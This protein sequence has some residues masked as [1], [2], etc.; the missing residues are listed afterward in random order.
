MNHITCSRYTLLFKFK[1]IKTLSERANGRRLRSMIHVV[2]SLYCITKATSTN[3]SHHSSYLSC[4]DRFHSWHCKCIFGAYPSTKFGF[5]YH[6]QQSVDSHSKYQLA[7]YVPAP[8]S[9]CKAEKDQ[10]SSRDWNLLQYSDD[11]PIQPISMSH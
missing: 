9:V 4:W 11:F 5:T 8:C 3:S 7:L 2:R 1:A 10:T 6:L